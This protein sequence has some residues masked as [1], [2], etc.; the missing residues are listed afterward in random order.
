MRND[1]FV[2][3]QIFIADIHAA[4]LARFQRVSSNMLDAEFT[5]GRVASIA[6]CLKS[7]FRHFLFC[8]LTS[9]DKRQNFVSMVNFSAVW[10]VNDTSLDRLHWSGRASNNHSHLN[11]FQLHNETINES[12]PCCSLPPKSSSAVTLVINGS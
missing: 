7:V 4:L 1:L 9:A 8:W 5:H 10:V 3:Y 6:E 11:L 2:N 12:V